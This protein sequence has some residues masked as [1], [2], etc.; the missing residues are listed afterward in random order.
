MSTAKFIV[1]LNETDGTKLAG[2]QIEP[3]VDSCH[4]ECKYGLRKTILYLHN[5][6]GS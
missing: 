5:T 1:M 4:D 3:F 2:G 6:L